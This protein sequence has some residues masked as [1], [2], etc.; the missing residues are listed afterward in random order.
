MSA[1]EKQPM[2]KLNRRIKSVEI[3]SAVK[4]ESVKLEDAIQFF[5]NMKKEIFAIT[6]IQNRERKKKKS[7]LG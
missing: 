1:V 5:L 3:D 6:A 7:C 4:K 2:Q